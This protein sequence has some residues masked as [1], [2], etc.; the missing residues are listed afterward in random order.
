M[1]SFAADTV[2]KIGQTVTVKGWVNSRRDHGGLIFVDVR[3]HSGVVQL[4]IQ[5]E[6][7]EAFKVAEQLRDEFVIAATG[8]VR[9]RSEELKNPNIPTGSIE[10]KVD[11]LTILN[12][13]EPLPIQIHGEALAN[14]ELRLKYRFLDLRRPKMQHMLEKRAEYYAFMRRYLEPLGFIEI[15]RKSVV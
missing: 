8:T 6:Q 15:D 5:P 13:S 9:E 3:D 10:I 1:R 11:E 4:V 12:R 14:E 7:S 2:N